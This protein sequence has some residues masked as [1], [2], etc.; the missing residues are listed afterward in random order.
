VIRHQVAVINQSTTLSDATAKAIAEGLNVQ[1]QR[2]FSSVW[3]IG[4][5]LSFVPKTA[6][7]PPGKW[8]LMILDNSDQAGALGYHDLTPE[9]LPL[10]KVFAATD[11]Q[12]GSIISVTASHELLEM[13]ADPFID[14]CVQAADGQT[15][16]A[17]ENCDACEADQLGYQVQIPD[18]RNVTVSDF[19]Y[20]RYFDA[21]AAGQGNVQLDH[22]NHISEPFQILP[23][24][25]LG[26][27]RATTGWTQ[28]QAE[29]MPGDRPRVG[30]RRERR[31]T[32]KSQW[33]LS[34]IHASYVHGESPAAMGL[35]PVEEQVL[36]Y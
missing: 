31:R 21:T 9:G 24:G 27:W 36:D 19:V 29:V 1:V 11:R 16:Y 12:Y 28:I 33:L 26:V 34:D 8:W 4:A 7:P 30:S 18:G 17:Y 2:D 25:Y 23:G 6:Q 13:L 22:G 20:P 32:P 35:L 5:V 3:G 14:L 15:F 10:G